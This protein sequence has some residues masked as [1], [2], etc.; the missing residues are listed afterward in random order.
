MSHPC[1]E[2]QSSG[3]LLTVTINRPEARNALNRETISE[4]TAIFSAT[5]G[6]ESPRCVL[7]TGAGTEAFCAG[8]DLS[9]LES[10]PSPED[11][12]A[13][14]RSVAN[15]ITSITACPIPVVAAVRGF[16]LAGGC[17]LVA[18]CDIAVAADDAIFGL[19]EVAIGL[20]PM[21][22]L[23]PLRQ[24]VAPGVLRLMA[25]RGERINAQR[26]LEA[27][28]VSQVV[29]KEQ[30]ESLIKT[31]CEGIIAQGPQAVRATKSALRDIQGV[32]LHEQMLDLADR[33]A[34]VSIGDE[35]VEGIAAFREKRAPSW[36]TR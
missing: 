11:R 28:L 20:A 18:A 17:G 23:A 7:L 1:V 3:H 21:V 24:R 35:A 31:L 27:G 25:I 15:L 12:R 5:Y 16:A 19:P 9:E 2:T 22:V 14:F 33:S 34:L 30:L 26:A 8:A 32:N 36:K 4:L 10:I 13:F 6:V 29:A